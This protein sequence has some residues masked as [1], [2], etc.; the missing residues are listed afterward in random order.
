MEGRTCDV[1]LKQDDQVVSC[2]VISHLGL[3]ER[4]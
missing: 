1:Q 4:L 2:D 3:W